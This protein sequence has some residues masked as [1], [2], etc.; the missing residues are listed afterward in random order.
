MIPD[1]CTGCMRIS[2]KL[3]PC[4][5][6]A[7]PKRVTL[8]SLLSQSPSA[9][10]QCFVCPGRYQEFTEGRLK[11]KTGCNNCGLCRACCPNAALSMELLSC[12]SFEEAL[13]KSPDSA[14]LGLKPYLKGI[15]LAPSVTASGNSRER[16]LD[17]VCVANHLVLLAKL[18]KNP[19]K[20][21]YYGRAYEDTARHYREKYPDFKFEP[22]LMVSSHTRLFLEEP[23]A[24]VFHILTPA[25][26]VQQMITH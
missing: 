16:R 5:L 6:N 15:N 13:F 23:P 9:F 2:D 4:I 24:G 26:L 12:A 17:L 7:A 3:P 8:D 14:F 21:S 10:R 22:C 25:Q 11:K 20:A 18:L 1:Y 19:E